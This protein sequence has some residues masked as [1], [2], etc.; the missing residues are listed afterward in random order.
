MVPKND[1]Q[2]IQARSHEEVQTNVVSVCLTKIHEK[3]FRIV[4]K[5]TINMILQ[6][7]I[8]EGFHEDGEEVSRNFNVRGVSVVSVNVGVVVFHRRIKDMTGIS[9]IGSP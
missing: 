3:I 8:K 4:D 1:V 6:E 5:M 2:A 7:K 9:I